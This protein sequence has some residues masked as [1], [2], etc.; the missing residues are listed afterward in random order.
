M[1][2]WTARYEDGYVTHDRVSVTLTDIPYW[3]QPWETPDEALDHW[4]STGLNGG[5]IDPYLNGLQQ[6]VDVQDRAEFVAAGVSSIWR[7]VSF[8]G[9]ASAGS[10]QC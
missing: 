7:R 3:E 9:L 1:S 10:Q 6:C 5:G 2:D 4:R 8:V